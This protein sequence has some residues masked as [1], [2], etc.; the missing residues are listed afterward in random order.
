MLSN[1]FLG[2]GY[3]RRSIFEK[4][5]YILLIRW[6]MESS[7]DEKEIENR[8]SKARTGSSLDLRKLS[9]SALPY[10]LH[11]DMNSF[12]HLSSVNLARNNLTKIP[13]ARKK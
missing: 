9:L 4:W 5:V 12:L 2:G 10:G 13:Q 8:I 1:K 6:K 3:E 7:A 11:D